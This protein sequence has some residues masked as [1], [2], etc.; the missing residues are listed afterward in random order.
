MTSIEQFSRDFTRRAATSAFRTWLLPLAL[1]AAPAAWAQPR[2]SM[3]LDAG[4]QFRTEQQPAWQPVTLPHSFN[5]AD[6]TSQ[7]YHR[8]AGWYRRT[9][10]LPRQPAD[11]R[12]FLEFDGAMLVTDVWVNGRHAGRHAGGFARFRFDVTRWLKPGRNQ[13]EVRVDNA[14]NPDVQPLGGDYTMAGGLYRQVRLVSTP[15]VHFD[16]LDYGGPGVYFKASGVSAAGATL[17]WTARVANDSARAVRTTVSARLRDAS[18]QVAASA[19]KTV[20]LPPRSVTTVA[21]AG[22]LASPHLWQG[23]RDP[24]LYTSEA[25]LGAGAGLLDRSEF[26]TGVRDIRLDPARGVLLNGA[27]YAVHGVNVHQ[28]F[29]PGKATAVTDADIDA[30]YRI[31]SDLGVTGVRHAHYQH[32]QRAYDL[33]DRMG[34]LVWTEMPLNAEVG[35]GQAFLANSVQQLRELLRQNSN[36]PSVMVW[37]LGNEIYKV[38]AA[39]ATVLALLQRVARR[40][41]P[42]RPTVYAN[43]CAPID[44]PQASHTDAAGSNVYY[45]W[46]DG[47]FA[48]LGPFLDNNHARRPATPLAVSEYGA[49]GSALQQQDPPQRPQPA[50]RWHPEQYQARYHEAAWPQLAQRSWLWGKFI[51]LGFDFPSA[52]RNEGD[53]PGFNDKGL[54]NYDRT[55]KKDAYFWYQANWTDGAS[56]PMAY[57]TSRRHTRRE[58]ADVEVKVYSNQPTARLAVNGVDLGEKAVTGHIATWPVRLAPGANR[59]SV[60]AGK[61]DDTVEWYYAPAPAR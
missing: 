10:D 36:H 39:S 7:K 45:G 18:G 16:M 29:L 53:Q 34:W 37:G 8:G 2:L 13:V 9:I 14:R 5:G 27:P 38:D 47:E 25:E 51:W 35:T 56:R 33:A 28:T 49:G 55:V 42:D 12:H 19:R 52:F 59:V 46:Y 31:L 54:V 6:S 1:C 22:T 17:G 4:W 32:P 15:A 41:E 43:C 57:I 60:T 20:S 50:G 61:A 26:K 30:D 58:T 40:E 24:Y 3:P 21:L 48:D 44:G 23:V 11:R